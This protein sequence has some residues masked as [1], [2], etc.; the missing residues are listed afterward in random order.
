[1]SN[2]GKLVS[3]V[4]KQTDPNSPEQKSATVPTYIVYAQDIHG[5]S[6]VFP[7]VTRGEQ[8][9]EVAKKWPYFQQDV[10]LERVVKADILGPDHR[11]ME[12]KV[13]ITVKSLDDKTTTASDSHV[14]RAEPIA[15]NAEPV[16]NES[17]RPMPQ[18]EAP[19]V[20][21]IRQH[22]SLEQGKRQLLNVIVKLPDEDEEMNF[23][24]IT[25]KHLNALRN[26]HPSVAEAI[27][28]AQLEKGKH[29]TKFLD[30]IKSRGAKIAAWH[31][32]ERGTYSVRVETR[33]GHRH[34][35]PSVSE[36]HMREFVPNFEPGSS[37]RPEE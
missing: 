32:T 35:Y 17:L 2:H 14:F 24:N 6:V 22:G 12:V 11:N 27:K 13:N 8:L 3:V 9:L 4:P 26:K 31:P 23:T 10:D 34:A 19:K 33:D 18:I 36:A 16:E 28:S 7:E 21:R 5:A 1:A 25:T 15:T 30:L 29:P 37:C 20:H